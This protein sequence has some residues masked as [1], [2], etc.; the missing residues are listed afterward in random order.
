MM[1]NVIPFW[2]SPTV[3]E[4][5]VSLHL[6]KLDKT[7][8]AFIL[9]QQSKIQIVNLNSIHHNQYFL[10][11]LSIHSL[12]TSW[13]TRPLHIVIAKLRETNPT[14]FSNVCEQSYHQSQ[15]SSR[16]LSGCPGSGKYPQGG[17]ERTACSLSP[18]SHATF[19]HVANK[20][21]EEGWCSQGRNTGI[22]FPTNF[23]TNQGRTHRTCVTQQLLAISWQQWQ[24]IIWFRR[25]NQ[26][27]LVINVLATPT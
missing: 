23:L 20:N 6:N 22:L 11:Y 21:E 1:I 10:S 15:L 13:N 24:P 25:R 14:R 16:Y 5:R 7:Q 27:R 12:I 3:Q 19:P 18:G 8:W 2:Q 9:Q 26:L 17:P 4:T